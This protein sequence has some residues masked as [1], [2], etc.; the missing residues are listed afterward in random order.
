MLLINNSPVNSVLTPIINLMVDYTPNEIEEYIRSYF[1]EDWFDTKT[2]S[3]RGND[4]R[5]NHRIRS[6]RSQLGIVCK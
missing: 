2:P 1:S 6:I 4:N 5:L 3:L